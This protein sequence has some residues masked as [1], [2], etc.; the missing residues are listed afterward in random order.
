MTSNSSYNPVVFI[1]SNKEDYDI[2][3]ETTSGGVNLV[4]DTDHEYVMGVGIPDTTWEDNYAYVQLPLKTIGNE[5]L[6]KDSHIFWHTLNQ[7]T[8]YTQ[9]IWFETDAKLINSSGSQFT[10][11]NWAAGHDLQPATLVNFGNNKYK[12]YSTYT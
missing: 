7:G 3:I 12:V 10:W 8:T 1:V 5:I 11:Y 2:T 9:T 4:S 6:P